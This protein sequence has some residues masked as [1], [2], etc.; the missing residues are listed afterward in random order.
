MGD[1][2]ILSFDPTKNLPSYGSGGMILTDD[3]DMY[4]ICRDLK[5]NGKFGDH[6]TPGTNS[7]M[8]EVDCAQMNVK[9]K[10]FDEWQR[11]RTEIA[12]YYTQE[13]CQ[14]VDVP[15]TTKGAVHAWHKYVIKV[16]SRHNLKQYLAQ[17]IAKHL[18]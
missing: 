3:Y 11:R 1:I 13:L 17:K 16:A 10:Y 12:E 7:K 5:D 14:Y 9:L 15:N 8:S 2:S 4:L 18:K 6:H